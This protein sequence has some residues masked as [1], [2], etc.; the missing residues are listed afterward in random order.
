MPADIFKVEQ[1]LCLLM[2]GSMPTPQRSDLFKADLV[3]GF[4][5]RV[6]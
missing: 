2:A 5:N 6:F 4:K 1:A 3:S